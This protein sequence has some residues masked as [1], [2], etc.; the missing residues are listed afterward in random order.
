M[1]ASLI[2]AAVLLAALPSMSGPRH[3]SGFNTVEPDIALRQ[4]FER[5]IYGAEVH[6]QGYRAANP[7][8]H[9]N[10]EFDASGAR[11]MHSKGSTTFRFLG[12]GYGENLRGPVP[13]RPEAGGSRVEYRRGP[14]TEWYSNGPD[15]LEQGFTLERR[16]G[17]A[18]GG[19]P[20]VIALAVEGELSPVLDQSRS[21]VLLESEG[22]IILRYAGLRAWDAE[23]R[24]A[25]A[26]LD[27]RGREVRLVIEDRDAKYP[28]VVDPGWSQQ[29]ELIASDAAINDR[30]GWA[31]AVSGDTAVIGAPNKTIGTNT[32]QGAAYVFV[33]NGGAW[34]QQAELTASDGA[35]NDSFGDSVAVSGDT[36]VVGADFKN[37]GTNPN[38]GA[39]YIFTRTGTAWS[40]QAELTAQDATGD[41]HFGFSVAISGETA[42]IGA[43]N[44]ATVQPFQGAAYVYV[45]SG[46]S[47]GLQTELTSGHT[48]VSD[49]QFG[50]SVSISGDTAV[51]G[52]YLQR[53]PA[54]S[55][56]PGAAYAFV[57]SGT[58]WSEQAEL[59]A[60][61]GL[62][63]DNFG[64]SV[65]VSGD[66]V[67]IGAP[68]KPVGTNPNQGVAYV[69]V[70]TGTSWSVQNELTASDGVAYDAFGFSVSLSGDA[71]VMGSPYKGFTNPNSPFQ[72]AAYGFTRSG[73]LWSQQTEL[74]G[75]D[76]DDYNEFGLS[77][78]ESGGTALI[79]AYGKQLTPN[80]PQG[81]AYAFVNPSV[82]QQPPTLS[83][84]KSHTGT[85][86]QGGTGEWDITVSNLVGSPSTV[87][88]TAVSD[89]LPTGYTVN[90]FA[91]TDPSWSCSGGATQTAT[92]TN[93]SAI[94]GGGSYPTI[95]IIVNIPANSP[96]S[97]TNTGK[98]YGGG[99]TVH[100]SLAT[101][102]AGSDTVTVIQVAAQIA[103]T[104]GTPQSTPINSAFGA[105]LQATV[106]DAGN[107]A[108]PN[109]SVTFQAP[110]TGAS[111]TFAAP[112]S[113]ATCVVT[114][115]ASGVAAA[116]AFTANG[117]VGGYHVTAMAG[118]AGPAVFSLN[119]AANSVNVSGQ[120]SVT[121]TGL[122]RNRGTGLW[123]GTMTVTN[124]SGAAIAGPVQVVLTNLTPGVTMV[125]NTG[126]F[127]GSP[128]IMVSAGALAPGA[129]A[130]VMIQFSNPSSGFISYTPVTY[131]GTP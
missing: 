131:S 31:V 84:A 92:C 67:L 64:R 24:P 120:V 98:A 4:A 23:G 19:E 52:A 94:A 75:S 36:V 27:V 18:E 89:T 114:T 112:C 123:T 12:Y 51:V 9:F 127:N 72:G 101:A 59:T 113:G 14:L 83:V 15:A 93:G 17:Q 85:F 35:T 87:G 96:T 107:V 76:S 65:S 13:A 80:V 57:R 74:I 1:H 110:S 47:W 68:A 49:E 3:A 71:G 22:R 54:T 118:A 56:S 2:L 69:L 46:T 122:S 119:N 90:S 104:A 78:S 5:T 111:G 86:T 41:D 77:V 43:P 129:A 40:Q 63:G 109:V 126:M 97:V 115:N 37:I 30:F 32:S 45:W 116:P 124:T 106:T 105:N 44:K 121:Q 91:S 103:A 34:S 25:K 38:G 79:G 10:V 100:T 48:T 33:R 61:D 53:I 73:T 108:I 20:L 21:A 88:A 55:T 58:T 130:S 99:D 117:T 125:G 29:A 42:V 62:T 7:A 26:W 28:L 82:N 39:A 102:A 95:K 50:I 81:V 128:Y 66:S 6:G 16:P 60:P 11:L 8:Q 70:R